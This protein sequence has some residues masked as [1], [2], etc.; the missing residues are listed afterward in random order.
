MTGFHFTK[1]LSIVLTA[2]IVSGF[3]VIYQTPVEAQPSTL[4]GRVIGTNGEPIAEASIAL[5]Y[6]KVAENGQMDTL[7]D[8]SLYPFL[9]Q[10]PAH[11]PEE[12]RGKTPGEDE[13]QARPPFLESKTDSEGQFTFTNIAAGMV[14]LMVLPMENDPAPQNVKP[15]PEIQTIKFG[16]VRFHP[17]DFSFFPPIGAITFAV[18]SDSTI[19]DVE[20]VIETRPKPKIQGR[21]IFK[22]GEPLADTTVKFNIGRLDLDDGG[23]PVFSRSLHTDADGN[24]VSVIYVPG[25][26]ALSV[27]HRG[28]SAMSAPF[29]VEADKSHEAAVL[30]LNGNPA[31]LSELPSERPE[32]RRY[33]VPDVPGVWIVNPANGHAY[34]WVACN[35]REDAQAQA[36]DEEAHLV[37]ITSETEQIW[38]EAVFG[39]GPYWIGLTD[40]L[41]EGE[42]IWE[43]GEPVT[44]TNWGKN[45]ED[46]DVLDEPPAL[47]KA[48]GAKGDRQGR[49]EGMNDYVIMSS[50]WDQ[51]IGRWYPVNSEGAGRGPHGRA[52]MAI[53]EKDGLQSKIHG[54]P[55]SDIIP[56]DN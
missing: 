14:Q 31:D 49:E 37:T 36:A 9:R 45:D 25:T 13:R 44:Y 2:V 29:T 22:N 28:L 19:K 55:L 11:F 47:L 48:F 32:E 51:E 56:E 20:V 43:T 38:L 12:L 24:F 15:V 42:W 17:H 35:D 33:G 52:S 16:E 30:R 4:S 50:R 41:K 3:A 10:Q 46:E 34:K 53:L 6:V 54:L 40:V 5:L 21:L 27:N 26:Y 18:K 7:Y 39:R 1:Q 23:D 8:R